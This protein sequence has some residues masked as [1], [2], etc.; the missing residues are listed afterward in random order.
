M[1]YLLLLFLLL[2]PLELLA[3]YCYSIATEVDTT[4]PVSP[5]YD[6]TLYTSSKCKLV[7]PP[8][9]FKDNIGL[10]GCY[11]KKKTAES[12]LKKISFPLKNPK[13]VYHKISLSDPYI[14]FPNRATLNLS[15][16]KKKLQKIY[17]NYTIEK[18]SKKFPTHFFGN[19]IDIVDF[20]KI[21]FLPQLNLY[22]LHKLN[23]KYA[24]QDKML[25]L[26]DGVY[27]L[28]MLY[29]KLHNKRYISKIND[30]T[31]EIKI[32]III[33]PTASLVIQ[34]KTIHLQTKPTSMF[35]TYYGKLYLQNNKFYTWDTKKN[36]YAKRQ[37]VPESKLLYLDYEDPR[38]YFIG[39][40]G[41][42]TYMLNN[43][44]K[45]I[46]VHSSVST[47]GLSLLF[48]PND[49]YYYKH[50]N[51]FN[52]FLSNK[53]PPKG[54]YVGNE[55]ANSCMGFYTNGAVDSYY[56]GNYLHDNVI[57]NFDPH[58]YSKGLVIARNIATKAGHA[59]GIIISRRVDHS[60]IAQ[61]ITL[62]N[63]SAGIMLDRLSNHNVIYD[64]FALAN[65]YMGI[66]IQESKDVLI[67]DNTVAMNKID[68]IIIRNSLSV[69]I[70]NN[71]VSNNGKNGIEVLSKNIDHTVKRNFARDPYYKSAAAVIEENRL[72][73][74]YNSN[75]MVKNS[76][77]VFLRANKNKGFNQ[78]GGDLNFF[79]QDILNKKGTFK[80]YGRGLPF[81][82][83]STDTEKLN[84]YAFEAAK[85]IYIEIADQP[86]TSIGTDLGIN[87]LKNNNR[88]LAE[89]EFQRAASNLTT[90]ALNYLG[91][92]YL[93]DARQSG[94]K[95]HNKTVEG[96]SFVIENAI[97]ENPQYI[98]LDKLLYF[99]PKS[100]PLIEEAFQKAMSRMRDGRLF[101]L[102]AYKSSLLCKNSLQKQQHIKAAANIF[103]YKMQEAKSESF[104]AY[105]KYLKK[106][107]TIFTRKNI[108]LLQQLIKEHNNLN[109]FAFNTSHKKLEVSG[110]NKLCRKYMQKRDYF[111]EQTNS[112]LK[113]HTKEEL[114]NMLPALQK[115]LD[116]INAFRK[117]KIPMEELLEVLTQKEEQ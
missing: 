20:Q 40:A 94:Y 90:G 37:K 13:I 32:P 14:I 59:H 113:K 8:Y 25:I 42:R 80:L 45:G 84:P 98:D 60:I 30:H 1:K 110:K 5:L 38:P 70:K 36:S 67:S 96:L 69:S 92:L 23:Q 78:F 81:H 73:N 82:A 85:K 109:S 114:R 3:N 83:K 101:P 6:K 86:N 64:N 112:L 100:A 9:L 46:G 16:T 72:Q 27:S 51:S 10:I 43:T 117:N 93:T 19:G 48:F 103:L 7:E 58:D 111:S 95:D 44:F 91:Y 87:Y 2:A 28:E 31:Y 99:I 47:F 11:K 65:G 33:A 104:L 15:K 57:Y 75:I 61:N 56:L 106:D 105:C 49:R 4:T 108:I 115:H 74:N 107:F 102:P 71:S 76:A 55:V 52:Y 97:M 18:V 17:N 21:T 77:A 116:E 29:K 34:N 68:G 26:Y 53:N 50:K 54:I 88:K 89:M 39:L 66:S 63:H 24:K 41:S 79:Y 35:I 62:K 12:V 22:S